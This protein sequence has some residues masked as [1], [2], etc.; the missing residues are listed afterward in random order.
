MRG[1]LADEVEWLTALSGMPRRPCD[2]ARC[3][4][5]SFGLGSYSWLRGMQDAAERCLMFGRTGGRF[6][7]Y[8]PGVR[9]THITEQGREALRLHRVIGLVMP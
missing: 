6:C 1:L 8:V 7:E 3:L 9:H 5:M 4:A 2:E